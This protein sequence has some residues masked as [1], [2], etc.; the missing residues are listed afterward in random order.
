V[1][2]WTF[3]CRTCDAGGVTT[4]PDPEPTTLVRVGQAAEMLGGP[5]ADPAPLV[6]G[7]FQSGGLETALATAS[8]LVLA[9]FGVLVAVRAL[10][11][12]ALDLRLWDWGPARRGRSA[13]PRAAS[14]RRQPSASAAS[15]T[16][17][18]PSDV[19][20]A[21]RAAPPVVAGRRF[22]V[23]PVDPRGHRRGTLGLVGHVHRDAHPN[24]RAASA[25]LTR[26]PIP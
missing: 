14:A 4:P 18:R 1:N 8:I 16:R 10:R 22:H 3:A 21:D 13:D 5:H 19:Q 25:R 6:Y 9:A 7:G 24:H 26:G 20:D 17:G 11:W 23:E 12:R 2:T 15:A